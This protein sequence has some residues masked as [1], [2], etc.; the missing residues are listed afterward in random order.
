VLGVRV[1]A[2]LRTAIKIEA[3]RRDVTIAEL[4]E[5]MWQAYREQKHVCGS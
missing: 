1:S 5:E 2:N 3:A 4:F